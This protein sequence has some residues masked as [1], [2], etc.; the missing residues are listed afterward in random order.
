M[1]SV[2]AEPDYNGEIEWKQFAG[3]SCWDRSALFKLW[4]AED[5][6]WVA[7]VFIA[8]G[9]WEGSGPLGRQDVGWQQ[10]WT[11]RSSLSVCL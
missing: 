5:S 2:Q 8:E 1:S 10:G 6:W 7:S 11:H 9:N 3:L 4:L